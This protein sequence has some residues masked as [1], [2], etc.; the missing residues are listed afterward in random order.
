MNQW[1]DDPQHPGRQVGW[2]EPETTPDYVRQVKRLVIRW[3]KRNGQTSY[4]MLISTLSTRDVLQ[5]LGQSASEARNPEKL[6]RAYAQLYD[7]RGC[8]VEIE[9]KEDKQVLAWSSGRSEKPRRSHA[10]SWKR[11]K[12]NFA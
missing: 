9:I 6:C 5:L 2:A 7:Q 1:Y 4:G 12:T 3:H 11:L 10:A 8:A